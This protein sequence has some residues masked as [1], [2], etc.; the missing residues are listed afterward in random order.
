MELVV[1]LARAWRN[2]RLCIDLFVSSSRA[3]DGVAVSWQ[4]RSSWGA[5]WV[6]VDSVFI[7]GRLLSRLFRHNRLVYLVIAG[8]LLSTV[9][10]RVVCR[11]VPWSNLIARNLGK[12][13]FVHS[14]V[15][16][17]GR[18]ALRSGLTLIIW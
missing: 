3:L 2:L 1:G 14:L 10:V 13:L 12:L 17:V 4:L 7:T 9:V 6:A 16:L 11:G 18:V 8:R 15:R 5:T